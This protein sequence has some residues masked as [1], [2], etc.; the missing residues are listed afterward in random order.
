VGY[1]KQKIPP[2]LD[3]AIRTYPLLYP[4]FPREHMLAESW[5]VSIPIK[6]FDWTQFV[7]SG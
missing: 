4:N 3:R 7:D 6:K 1:E 2:S 5:L